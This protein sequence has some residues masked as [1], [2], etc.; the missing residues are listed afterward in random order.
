MPT[1]K[2]ASFNQT[3]NWTFNNNLTFVNFSLWNETFCP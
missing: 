1:I 2:S 3:S